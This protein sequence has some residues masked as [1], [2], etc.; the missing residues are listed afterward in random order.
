[1]SLEALPNF[2]CVRDRPNTNTNFNVLLVH[3]ID[4]IFKFVKYNYVIY[5]LRTFL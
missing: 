1:M 2:L 3:T 5:M 4:A